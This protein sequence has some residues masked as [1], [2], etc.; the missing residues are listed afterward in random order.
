[1]GERLDVLE[2]DDVGNKVIN[3]AFVPD[4]VDYS[5]VAMATDLPQIAAANS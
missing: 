1:M 2:C 4:S 5:K 3:V